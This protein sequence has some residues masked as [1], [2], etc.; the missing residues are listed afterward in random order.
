MF[1]N[2][3]L[4]CLLASSYGEFRSIG[5]LITS[6]VVFKTIQMCDDSLINALQRSLPYLSVVVPGGSHCSEGGF[7]SLFVLKLECA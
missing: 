3:G 5:I 4:C 2:V 7:H 6:L 1:V